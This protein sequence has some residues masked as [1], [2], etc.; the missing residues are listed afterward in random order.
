M[1]IQRGLSRL[2]AV[3]WGAV[4]LIGFFFLAEAF[5]FWADGG[6]L[7]EEALWVAAVII[8]VSYAGWRASLWVLNGFFGA[9]APKNLD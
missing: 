4:S 8:G 2:L 3:F 6:H 9:D 5:I 7:Q 1:N